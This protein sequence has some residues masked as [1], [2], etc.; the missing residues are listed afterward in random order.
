[1]LYEVITHARVDT[2][3][4][5]LHQAA[6]FVD[7]LDRVEVVERTR[8]AHRAELAE[9]VAK[10]QCR[11]DPA[12]ILEETVRDQRDQQDRRLGVRNNFV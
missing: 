11:R 7:E 8:R 6:A 5:A 10:E 2:V 3:T 1:M 9:G 4:G 12:G